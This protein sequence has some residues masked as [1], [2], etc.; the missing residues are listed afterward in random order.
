[1][2]RISEILARKGAQVHRIT[3]DATAHDALERLVGLGIGSLVVVSDAGVAGIFT[4]R[5]F[6]TRVAL[7]G[8]DPRRTR[9]RDVM[10]GDLIYV[11]PHHTVDECMAVMTSARIR[12][13]PVMDGDRLS[14][15][16]SI[17]D[18]VKHVS[19]Q[20]EAEIRHLNGYIDGSYA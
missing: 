18:L 9:L 2:T 20:R 19:L 14:G 12:H 13:L 4:E 7:P 1:M 11:A 6:L 15:L 17:G 3:P 16:I 5:D 8:L 10:T